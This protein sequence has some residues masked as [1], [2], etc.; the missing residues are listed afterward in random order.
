MGSTTDVEAVRADIDATVAGRTLGA[1]FVETVNARPD[2]VALR[3]RGQG[4]WLT[5]TWREYANQAGRVAAGLRDLGIDR[6]Q[7]VLLMLRNRPEFH[8]TDLAC[9]LIGATPFSVYNSSSAEQLRYIARHSGARLAIVDSPELAERLLIVRHDLPDL[10]HLAIVDDP[11]RVAPA[12]VIGFDHLATRPPI[13]W[14]VAAEAIAPM[15]P[16]T[17]IYT[18]G[19]TGPPKAV[20]ITQRNVCWTAESL[21]R[22]YDRPLI[23]RRVVSYLPMAHIAERMTTHYIHIHQ[24]TEVTCCPDVRQLTNYLR[25]VRPQ[26]FFTVPRVWEKAHSSI[27]VLAAADPGRATELH[28]AIELGRRKRAADVAGMALPTDVEAAWRKADGDLLSIV[29]VLVGLDACEVAVSAAAPIP[30]QIIEYFG[31]LGVPISELY[32]LSESCGP[33]T[34][35]AHRVKPGR[36]GVAIPGCEVRLAGDG[37]ILARGGNIFS[38]YL[39]DPERTAEALDDQGWLHTGD[40]GEFDDEGYLRVIDRKKDLI[41]TAGGKNISPAN[42]ESALRAEPL[43]GQAVVVGDAKPYLVALLTLDAEVAHA[44]ARTRAIENACLA[45]LARHRDVLATVERSVEA[46]NARLSQPERIKRFIV[47]PEEWQ[48]DSAQLTATTKLKR[49]SVLAT[50][51]PQIE[52]LYKSAGRDDGSVLVAHERI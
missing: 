40:I 44:W 16:A 12:D 30:R 39:D 28:Q 5:M 7:R 25:D 2:A 49:R 31:A 46:V 21:L 51:A 35:S 19:T 36:T 27:E 45:D 10:A 42:I 52:A 4:D 22:A 3:W 41:I 8:V 29:R 9:L 13:D 26:V 17:L 33:L 1:V 15:D 23:G 11:D 37:E 20:M 34:W 24:G 43:I 32:G 48:P 18:S 14:R 6:G 38:G 50:Y 47:L